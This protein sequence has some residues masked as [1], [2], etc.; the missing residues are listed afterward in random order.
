MCWDPHCNILFTFLFLSWMLNFFSP[1]E[2][3]SPFDLNDV[4]TRDSTCGLCVSHIHLTW[5][6]IRYMELSHT[7]HL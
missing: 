4:E 3:Y 7:P 2:L 1:S 5:V 6:F